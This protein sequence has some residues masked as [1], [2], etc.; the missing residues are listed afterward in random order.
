M[1]VF[2]TEEFNYPRLP[3]PS[4]HCNTFVTVSQPSSVP[5][6]QGQ[7]IEWP[8]VPGAINPPSCP[9]ALTC[10]RT[11]YLHVCHASISTVLFLTYSLSLSHL[12]PIFSLLLFLFSFFF[13][14]L[15][16]ISSSSFFFS[17]SLRCRNTCDHTRCA[18][19]PRQQSP[20]A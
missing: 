20:A 12:P 8:L 15:C 19:P 18:L 10:I 1:R 14:F 11:L 2:H 4:L 3:P 6:T 16:L 9:K 17:C 5:T 13:L 7:F